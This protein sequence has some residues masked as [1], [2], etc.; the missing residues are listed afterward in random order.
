MADYRLVSVAA[1]K[2]IF[3]VDDDRKLGRSLLVSVGIGLIAS[4]FVSTMQFTDIDYRFT[5]YPKEGI[6]ITLANKKIVPIE[7]EIKKDNKPNK[8]MRPK[9]DGA[10]V[11]S[12]SGIKKNGNRADKITSAGLLAIL[13]SPNKSGTFAGNRVIESYAKDIDAYTNN[14]AGVRTVGRPEFGRKD[15]SGPDIG[16]GW[17]D[18]GVEGGDGIEAL[19][20]KANSVENGTLTMAKKM[21]ANIGIEKITGISG[22]TES[23]G[24]RSPEGIRIVVMNHMGGLRAEYN[25][26]LRDN[27]SLKGKIAVRFTINPAGHVT[28]CRTLINTM[29][30]PQLEKLIISRIKTWQFESCMN[31]GMATVTY[32][33]V[34][35]Q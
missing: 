20:Q 32:P 12:K 14:M 19:L 24:G 9:A 15:V 4:V 34:F 13:S 2:D 5:E 17:T 21:P 6:V 23:M 22:S 33:F 10:S 16:K 11:S 1:R 26:R 29:N 3:T 28:E 27:P 25:K 35:S 30:D 18:G 31:C 7:K 8:I